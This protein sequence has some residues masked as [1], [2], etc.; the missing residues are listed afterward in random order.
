MSRRDVLRAGTVG[1]GS[2][3]LMLPELAAR[4]PSS[5]GGDSRSVILLLLV[6]GPSQLET[7]DPKPDAPAEVRG[8]FGSIPT[9]IPGIRISEFLPKLAARMDRLA[10]IRS[11]HH[12][13]AP[14]HETGLQL[15]QTGRLCVRR[16]SENPHVGAVAAR[17][18]GGRGPLP[19]S[20]I[21]PSPIGN[22]GVRISRGQ[23][24]GWLG[25]EPAASPG[26]PARRAFDL[27]D[28]PARLREAYGRSAFG[29]DCLLARRLVERG[30]RLVTVNM[31]D[32]VF[33]RTTWDCHGAAPFSTLD[34][35]AGNLLPTLD[36]AL[37]ALLDDLGARG[38]LDTTMVVATG[39]FGR[40]PRLNGAGGRDHWPGVWSALAAGGGIRGGTVVGASDAIASMPADRPVAPQELLA[41]IGHGLGL[42]RDAALTDPAGRP[43][44]PAGDAEPIRELFA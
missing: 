25:E 18:L 43:Y 41:T 36:R 3:G 23:A 34:D 39:E 35:Y 22:T 32:T 1:L 8:P 13:A 14:I 37:S 29:R 30:A 7:W 5:G 16:D 20:M 11:M 28:E 15:L 26:T 9:K 42:A 31:F 10:L 12:D 24:S 19:P 40:T 17:L 2:M 6:G 27:A 4:T 44:R 33:D 38:L 21:V